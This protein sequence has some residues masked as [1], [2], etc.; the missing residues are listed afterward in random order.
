LL[1]RAR[2]GFIRLMR[3]VRPKPAQAGGWAAKIASMLGVQRTPSYIELCQLCIH[4]G[5]LFI[6]ACTENHMVSISVALAATIHYSLVIPRRPP[7]AAIQ[8]Y[9][10]YLTPKCS[11]N[12]STVSFIA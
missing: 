12:Q 7:P 9:S 4:V 11:L 6:T 3:L 2:V 8:H 1:A 5:A 10:N